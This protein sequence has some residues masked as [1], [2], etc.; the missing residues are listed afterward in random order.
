[1]VRI[2]LA[3]DHAVVRRMLRQLLEEAPGCTVCGEACDGAEAVRLATELAPDVAVLDVSMPRL[4]GLQAAQC[5]RAASPHTVI[6]IVTLY[7]TDGLV[8]EALLAGACAY[9]LKRDAPQHLVPAVFALAHGDCP[10][11]TPQ[12]TPDIWHAYASAARTNPR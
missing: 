4:S 1:M 6:L 5:I 8:R 10:Y 11:F 3:D 2:L 9:L 7:E 12:L